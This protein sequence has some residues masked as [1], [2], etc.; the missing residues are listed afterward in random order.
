VTATIVA[1][2]EGSG[3]SMEKTKCDAIKGQQVRIEF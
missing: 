1:A 2:G 3:D